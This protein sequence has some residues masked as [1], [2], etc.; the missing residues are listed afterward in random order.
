MFSLRSTVRSRRCYA[1]MQQHKWISGFF[2]WGSEYNRY[3]FRF[4][5]NPLAVLS[6]HLRCNGNWN[7]ILRPD[8]WE[9]SRTGDV[10]AVESDEAGSK[11]RLFPAPVW[12]VTK[13]SLPDT[14][15][16]ASIVWWLSFA[17]ASAFPMDKSRFNA[18]NC[19]WVTT[20]SPR[21]LKSH[22]DWSKGSDPY[23][24]R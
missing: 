3:S 2:L 22:C 12:A 8:L 17:I 21:V 16:Y 18:L 24:D 7:W 11:V 1:E 13:T 20:L 19:L 9:I 5:N 14:K 23:L 10:I 15:I 4:Q 6:N